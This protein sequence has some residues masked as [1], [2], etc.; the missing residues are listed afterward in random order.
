MTITSTLP[1]IIGAGPTGLSAALFLSERGIRSR[2]VDKA[3]EPSST[4]RA[5]VVNPRSLELLEASGV[6]DIILAESRAI[7]G[8][9]FY[10]D[11]RLLAKLEFAKL[12]SRYAMRVIPQARTEAI[13]IEALKNRGLA[14]ERGIEL[15]DVRQEKDT[16]HAALKG[17]NT[18]E[19]I[20]VPLLLA[21]DGSHSRV[22][23]TLG[24]SFDGHSFPEAWPLYDIHLNDPLDLDHAHVS[25]TKAGLVFLL[26]IRPG[27]WRL[28]GNVPDL[29]SILP[30][31]THTGAVE[32]QSSFHVGDKFAGR[33]ALGRVAI[34][35]DAAH[36]HS[37]IGARGM[38]LGIEDAWVFAACAVDVLAG[39]SSRLAD[40]GRMRHAVHRKVVTRMN[41]LTVL[42]RGRP[43]LL[44]LV[45]HYLIPALIGFSP[46]ANLM[47]LF[48]AGVDQPT[49]I[50]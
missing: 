25:F 37:A 2:I 18:S 9:Q 24:I 4:S 21:A 35:G 26:A 47:E 19:E 46:L 16:V 39:D 14:A 28:F 40:Y 45:R 22:R 36:I 7:K 49:E 43:R 29:L 1:L 17:N 34:A 12:P 5:Q 10:E 41:K 27:L 42:A 38:N 30:A 20:S 32:W 15:K 33:A 8:V 31:G 3:L 6:S 11:W 23:E 48:I 13:L 50:R 44:G